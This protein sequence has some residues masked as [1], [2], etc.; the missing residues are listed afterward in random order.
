MENRQKI[1]GVEVSYYFYCKRRCWLFSRGLQME[2]T[3]DLVY[4]GKVIDE[5]S[6]DRQEKGID[7]DGIINIDWI[8]TKTGV[9]HEVKKSDSVEK[10]HEM[11]VLYYLWYLKQKGIGVEGFLQQDLGK[12]NLQLRGEIDYPKLKQKTVVLL[13]EEKEKELM[14]AIE[15]IKKIILLDEPPERIN[16]K[17]CKTCSYFELCWAE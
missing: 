13:T 17:F 4:M 16:K 10:A 9:I 1:T 12:G 3:S 11:Q 6:Y 14:N 5:T 2:Q 8:D 7:I 15:E